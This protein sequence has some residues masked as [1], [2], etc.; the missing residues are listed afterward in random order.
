MHRYLAQQGHRD[1]RPQVEVDGGRLRADLVD[2]RAREVIE[3]KAHERSFV[4]AVMQ[5]AHYRHELNLALGDRET[6]FDRVVVLLPAPPDPRDRAFVE[7]LYLI[8]DVVFRQSG[9]FTRLVLT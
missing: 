6:R 3:A 8:V 1:L 4:A 5:A 2:Y 7:T 9:T